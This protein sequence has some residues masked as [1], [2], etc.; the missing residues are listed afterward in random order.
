MRILYVAVLFASVAVG[1]ASSGWLSQYHHK[2]CSEMM[3]AVCSDDNYCGGSGKASLNCSVPDSCSEC[4]LT[5]Y[6]MVGYS[7]SYDQ[8]QTTCKVPPTVTTT[9]KAKLQGLGEIEGYIPV[10]S[11][12]KIFR[13]IPYAAPP[14]GN[15]RFRSPQPAES[16]KETL[17]TKD[18]KNP[19]AQLGPAWNS[20]QNIRNSS[21]D[22]LYLNIYSPTNLKPGKPAPV[23]MYVP[24]GQYMWG[25]SDD[26]E[27]LKAPTGNSSENV[28]YVTLGYR[29][30]PF[31]FLALPEIKEWGE[32]G[33]MGNFAMQDQRMALKFLKTHAAS[34]GGDP[35]NIILWGESAG[36]TSVSTQLVM[37]KSF[38][39][40]N[41]AIIES[42][43]FNRWTYKTLDT[44]IAK[45]K[46]SNVKPV[47][48][49]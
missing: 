39:Y 48:S 13:G 20:L 27:N 22:C 15:L 25:A 40:F 1:D 6:S 32:G 19:C 45:L 41:K 38:P 26:I 23:M 2:N 24:A 7:C 5:Y 11:K 4:G 47:P 12:H 44:A 36:A 17:M 35:N 3:K 33:S 29:V 49:Y 10:G 21:E 34:F 18:F 16:W 28:I 37:K 8:L 43:A 46:K 30:G 14:V 31:G 9:T 42:G